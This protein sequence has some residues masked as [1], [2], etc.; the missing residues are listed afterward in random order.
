[1]RTVLAKREQADSCTFGSRSTFAV[2]GDKMSVDD[3]VARVV[4]EFKAASKPQGL[5]A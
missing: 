5:V 3:E 1:M 4:Q 2:D